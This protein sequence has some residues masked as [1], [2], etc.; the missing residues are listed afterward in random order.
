MIPAGGVGPTASQLF[1]DPLDEQT[2]NQGQGNQ[3][4]DFQGLVHGEARGEYNWRTVVDAG[5]ESKALFATYR[6][7]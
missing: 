3:Q 4:Q 5:N 2:P 1:E 7:L 6:R